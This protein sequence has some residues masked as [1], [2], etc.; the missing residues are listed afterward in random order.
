MI[1]EKPIDTINKSVDELIDQINEFFIKHGLE[2]EKNQEQKAV[3]ITR[4]YI[5]KIG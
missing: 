3:L 2:S 4:Y 5:V 1:I